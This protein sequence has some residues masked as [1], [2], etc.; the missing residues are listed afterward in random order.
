MSGAVRHRNTRTFQLNT[1]QAGDSLDLLRSLPDASAALVNFDPQHRGV[2]NHLKFGN[3]GARQRG[4]SLL[5]AMTDEYIDECLHEAARVL[6]PSGYVI[7]WADTFQVGRGSHLRV[8]DV[9][10]CVD[11]LAWDSLRM[12]MGKRSRR[13]GDYVFILQRPPITAKNWT[14]HSIPS[15]WPEKVDRKTHPHIKP[16]GLLTRLIAA[17]TKVG[18]TVVDSCAGSFLVLDICRELGRTFVGVDIAYVG[19]VA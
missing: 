19:A 15:R 14:D 9:L 18:D 16:R 6:V 13:R 12:G 11:V 17:T 8:D 10:P 1:A 5:P 4:R 7:L 3:E 2:L